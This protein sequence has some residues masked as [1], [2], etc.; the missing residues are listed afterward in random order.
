VSTI[1]RR[2]AA[3]HR[4]GST[5]DWN[6]IPWISANRRS[7]SMAGSVLDGMRPAEMS[8]SMRRVIRSPAD[9]ARDAQIRVSSGS[10]TDMP[11]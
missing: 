1:R 8:A 7:L 5:M 3:D 2:Y 11:W 10:P 4:F 6:D 9:A